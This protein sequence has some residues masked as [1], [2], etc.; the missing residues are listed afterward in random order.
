VRVGGGRHLLG[1]H[2]GPDPDNLVLYTEPWFAWREAWE[3]RFGKWGD[4]SVCQ[5]VRRAFFCSN[6][7]S[8]L[9]FDL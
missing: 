2:G 5:A 1:M 6:P 9:T 3:E 4:N 8:A 7:A